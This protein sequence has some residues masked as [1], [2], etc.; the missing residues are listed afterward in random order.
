MVRF[1]KPPVNPAWCLPGERCILQ[2]PTADVISAQ[3]RLHTEVSMPSIHWS[4]HPVPKES[5][6]P[7]FH[8]THIAWMGGGWGLMI[9]KNNKTGK[10]GGVDE[11]ALVLQIKKSLWSSRLVLIIDTLNESSGNVSVQKLINTGANWCMQSSRKQQC[12]QDQ[13]WVMNVG[14]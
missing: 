3:W 9:G 12:K 5:D 2:P 1:E 4:T 7:H 14:G 11:L 8:L 10:N 6:R 13:Q